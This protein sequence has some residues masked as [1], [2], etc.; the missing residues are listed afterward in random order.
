MRQLIL[1]LFFIFCTGTAHAQYKIVKLDV[2]SVKVYL[3]FFYKS[4]N[5]DEIVN[6]SVTIICRRINA[7]HFYLDKYLHDKKT[8]TKKCELEIA[9]DSMRITTRT[10]DSKSKSKFI[11]TKEQYFNAVEIK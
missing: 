8:W 6:D 4:R 11:Y 7:D 9:K 1:L 10:R 2:D 5:S 3:R